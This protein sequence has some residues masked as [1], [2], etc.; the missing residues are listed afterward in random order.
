MLRINFGIINHSKTQTLVT[1]AQTLAMKTQTLAMKDSN[2][3]IIQVDNSET[4]RKKVAEIIRA[5]P[6][7]EY[8]G[9]FVSAEAAM[10][11]LSCN[12]ADMVLLDTDLPGKDGLWLATILSSSAARI[13]FPAT[14]L[15]N[16]I[17]AFEIFT[18]HYM[19]K[20]VTSIQIETII[21][22]VWG[23]HG[24][25]T[26]M[27]ASQVPSL[28]SYVNN[29]D[30]PSRILLKSLQETLI[31]E[32]DKVM[33]ISARRSCTE[34]EMSTGEKIT[35]SKNLKVYSDFIANNPNFIRVH[36][37]HIVNKN[38]IRSITQRGHTPQL[39]MKN[40]IS[41]DVSYFRKNDIMQN[42]EK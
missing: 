26:G 34:F 41:L 27:Q 17:A 30:Y 18:L 5:I 10:E 23:I 37:S 33:Y 31:V 15:E 42:L 3:K 22:R 11:W 1:K 29:T 39:V 35:V 25:N 40:G 20:P 12:K 28:A 24:L 32:L 2:L 36:R 13:A 19:V 8:A 14:H 7:I 38:Y 4:D 9:G 21:D 6:N 16:T